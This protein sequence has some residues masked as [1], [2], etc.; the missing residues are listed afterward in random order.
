MFAHVRARLTYANVVATLA[1]FI[2][3]GSGATAA[4]VISGR[5]VK[6]GSLTGKDI[7]NNSVASTDVKNGSLVGKDFKHGQLPGGATGPT[8]AIGATGDAGAPGAKGDAGATGATGAKG[9]AGVTGAKGDAGVTGAKGDTG[10]AGATGTTGAQGDTGA[11]G[12]TGGT[13]ATGATGVTGVTGSTATYSAGSGLDLTGSVFSLAAGGVV[14]ADFAPTAKAPDADKLDGKDSTAF[15]PVCPSGY[16]YD[17]ALCFEASDVGGTTLAQAANR[18]RTVGARLPTLAD[19]DAL[20]ASGVAF[21]GGVIFDWTS[22]SVT[23][24]QTLY[25]SG[26]TTTEAT[27]AQRDNSTSSYGRCFIEP[28]APYG[29]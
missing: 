13:G 2:A 24:T 16:S 26:A 9:D 1:L 22:N 27:A 19:V 15:S 28:H 4:V 3:L 10:T 21:A 6:D 8:G 20:L 17:G 5:N 14:T 18:C 25:I 23:P 12:A 7:K 11:K 29:G